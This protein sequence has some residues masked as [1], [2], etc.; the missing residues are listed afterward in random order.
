MS[1]VAPRD[2]LELQLVHVWE[3]TLGVRPIGVTTNFFDFGGHSLLAVSLMAHI[4]HTRIEDMAA[5]YIKALRV[6]QPQGPYWLGGYSFGGLVAFE[7]AQQLHSQGQRVALL[8]LLD[9]WAPLFDGEV[10]LFEDDDAK[11]IATFIGKQNLP[12]PYDEFRQLDSDEQALC[13]L[14]TARKINVMPLGAGLP[15]IRRFL[16]VWKANIRATASYMPRIYPNCITLFKSEVPITE[17]DLPE[18]RIDL[19]DADS[20]LGWGK[21]SAQ[22]V[23]VCTVP[24]THETMVDE[25]HVQILA[26]R[27]RSY[28]NAPQSIRD[29]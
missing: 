14:E 6:V 27:L 13:L 5:H 25:P 7:M 11:T 20:T 26:E 15:E 2:T 16:H 18:S 9:T 4:Q 8:A 22:P 28:L 12:M 23:T 1:Y 17:T 29:R 10:D 19:R 21:L 3:T 24:G